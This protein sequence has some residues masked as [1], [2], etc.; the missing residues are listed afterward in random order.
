MLWR[1]TLRKPCIGTWKVL[2]V[3]AYSLDMGG[4]S[5][6]HAPASA[7]PLVLAANSAHVHAWLEEDAMAGAME[8]AA[9]MFAVQ[10]DATSK[11]ATSKDGVTSAS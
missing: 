8:A 11:I 5:V 7:K 10:V 4:S 1:S 3:C 9:A 6:N 2:R